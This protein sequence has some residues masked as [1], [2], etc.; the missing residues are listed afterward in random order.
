MEQVNKCE[1]L[2]AN[3]QSPNRTGWSSWSKSK[4]VWWVIFNIFFTCI[5]LVIYLIRRLTG[6]EN[7]GNIQ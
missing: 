7:Y 4:K 5:P 6:G 2:I 1:E 3:S